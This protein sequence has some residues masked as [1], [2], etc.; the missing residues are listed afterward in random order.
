MGFKLVQVGAFETRKLAKVELGKHL[1]NTSQKNI[2]IC[3][4]MVQ[5]EGPE[6]VIFLWFFRVPS[7]HGLYGVPGQAPGLKSTSKR[8]PRHGFSMISGRC[9]HVILEI[10]WKCFMCSLKNK[11]IVFDVKF[12]FMLV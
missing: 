2:E 5:K 10:L 11:L 12:M 6:K 8:R 3:S 4:K 9:F 1:K 7:Q